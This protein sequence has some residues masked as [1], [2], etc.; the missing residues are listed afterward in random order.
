[1]MNTRRGRIQRDT[2]FKLGLFYEYSNLEYVHFHV[3]FHV[4]YRVNQ[5]GYVIRF[6]VAA[7]REYVNTYSTCR[8]ATHRTLGPSWPLPNILSRLGFCARINHPFTPPPPSA[9]HIRLHYSCNTI[10]QYST[11]PAPPPG[12]MPY[13]IEYYAWQYRVKAKGTGT[14]NVPGR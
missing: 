9:L 6:L 2:L 14:A 11:P 8:V 1:M 10:A 7:S 12:C 5:A 13:T 3:H 4:I